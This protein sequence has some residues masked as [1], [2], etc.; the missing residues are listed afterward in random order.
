MLAS[1]RRMS[2]TVRKP[3]SGAN[4][5]AGKS[6]VVWTV[7]QSAYRPT[8]WPV[9]ADC[10]DNIRLF[11]CWSDDGGS[12][13]PCRPCGVRRPQ[14]YCGD[15]ASDTSLHSCN[16]AEA[17]KQWT[18]TTMF[19]PRSSNRSARCCFPSSRK[20]RSKS[21]GGDNERRNGSSDLH[22][23]NDFNT[24]NYNCCTYCIQF[25]FTMVLL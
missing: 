20:R 19:C 18:T 15:D 23:A 9:M 11:D 1:N 21:A 16:S 4:R 7:E 5:A 3:A 13:T 25:I 24:A 12:G 14:L 22:D 10:E 2:T 6:G 17:L 8:L